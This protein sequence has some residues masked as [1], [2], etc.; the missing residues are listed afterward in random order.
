MMLATCTIWSILLH[1]RP[2][3][4]TPLYVISGTLLGIAI[5]MGLTVKNVTDW[6]IYNVIQ[7]WLF[8]SIFFYI[9]MTASGT[10]IL[11]A[12]HRFKRLWLRHRREATCTA[13]ILAFCI[14]IPLLY[15]AFIGKYN[16]KEEHLD[17]K[18]KNLPKSFDGY[19]ITVF[20]D[21]HL[22]SLCG[23]TSRLSKAIDL[24]NSTHADALLFLGDMVNCFPGETEGFDPLFKR[25]NAPLRLAIT[26]NHDRPVSYRNWHHSTPQY[27]QN[28]HEI[29][30]RFLDF[31]FTP[32]YNDW[33]LVERGDESIVIGGTAGSEYHWTGDTIKYN[34]GNRV[35]IIMTHGPELL[36]VLIRNCHPDLILTGHTHG[37]QIGLYLSPEWH[38]T[39]T[40]EETAYK[41]GYFNLDG[42]HLI[43][44]VG[45][46]VVGL[47]MRIG[48]PP[49]ITTIT[50]RRDKACS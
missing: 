20:S 18:I 17:L 22:G 44:N 41:A 15:G 47:P 2:L 8:A 32:L 12:R 4:L 50:L 5:H 1:R 13:F 49:T 16:Y 25:L 33:W 40:Q 29:L 28:V 6:H 42:T 38:L 43:V 48:V 27:Q 7:W 30:N 39:T 46:G 19:R 35:K 14:C 26:G 23:D 37:G 10:A 36:D 21:L 34:I 31:G 45:L 11:F 24:I 3:W 9:F